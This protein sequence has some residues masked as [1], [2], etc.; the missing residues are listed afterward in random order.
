MPQSPHQSKMTAFSITYHIEYELSFLDIFVST[1]SCKHV[2]A[3]KIFTN[4]VTCMRTPFNVY[5][6]AH[7]TT[8][9]T[10]K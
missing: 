4:I 9:T 6:R 7:A 1:T 5:I 10:C 2:Y 3:N 8:Q